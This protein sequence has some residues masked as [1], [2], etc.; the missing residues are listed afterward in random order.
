MSRRYSKFLE[1]QQAFG[2]IALIGNQLT[3]S[4]FLPMI[5]V[6]KTTQGSIGVMSVILIRNWNKEKIKVSQ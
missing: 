4:Q 6:C 3:Q 2:L 5:D 1:L